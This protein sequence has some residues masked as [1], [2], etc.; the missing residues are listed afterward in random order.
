VKVRKKWKVEILRA[1]QKSQRSPYIAQFTGLN[2]G[3]AERASYFCEMA[4]IIISLGLGNPH[5]KSAL[6]LEPTHPVLSSEIG[7]AL[8]SLD[9]DRSL[10]TNFR[11]SRLSLISMPMLER[12]SPAS[13]AR[14]FLLATNNAPLHLLDPLYGFSFYKR[15]HRL[16]NHCFAI[17]TWMSHL[18]S[19]PASL[20]KTLWNNRA[21]NMLSGGAFAARQLFKGILPIARDARE[22]ATVP[23]I[24]VSSES[25]LLELTSHLQSSISAVPGLQLW[26]RGQCVEYRTPDRSKI[27]SMGIAP[28]S[29]IQESDLTPSLYRKY[30][31]YLDVL[32]DFQEVVIELAEW[33]H[34]A[35]LVTAE[36]RNEVSDSPYRG[37]ASVGKRG[38]SSYQK[39]LLLQQYGA[40]SAYL[41]ITSDCLIAAWFA[42]R[43]CTTNNDRRMIFQD[44]QWNGTRQQDWPIIFVFPLVKGLHPFLDLRAILGNTTALRPARQKCGLLGGAGNLA[45]NYCAR[46]MGLKIRLKPG[47]SL[48]SPESSSDLFPPTRD[49]S[50]LAFLQEK[51]LGDPKRRFVVS[52]L[53]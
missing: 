44:Y 30:D 45:R 11:E 21:D 51:G 33:A 31:S 27:V 43:R 3:Q 41:D 9:I 7:D 28:Y 6:T 39:G 19:M 35:R 26:F 24:Y 16:H 52:D 12:F 4:K 15:D 17:D 48:S 20:A 2:A 22:R 14:N 50:T 40:P 53:A 37:V 49:D 34:C 32:E 36:S 25:E 29:N 13:D 8:D 10:R 46:Y 38:M 42:T 5:E 47:F 1:R 23:E 18:T